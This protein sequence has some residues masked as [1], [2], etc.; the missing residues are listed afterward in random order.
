MTGNTPA[1]SDFGTADGTALRTIEVLKSLGF[2]PHQRDQNGKPFD[3]VMDFGDFQIYAIEGM[4]RQFRDIV[5]LAGHRFTTGGR[6]FH[7]IEFEM[8]RTVESR[9]QG[10]AWLA[11]CLDRYASTAEESPLYPV[12]W[13]AEGRAHFHLLHWER[14]RAERE[15]RQQRRLASPHCY[16]ERE[17]LR[18]ALRRLD[19]LVSDADEDEPIT[20]S[21]DGEI[22]A[23]R[24]LRRLLPVPADGTAWDRRYS[25]PARTWEY[26]RRRF[27]DHHV[28]IWIFEG[29]LSIDTYVYPGV[30]AVDAE[31]S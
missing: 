14:E 12:P 9:E 25:I 29:S 2:V 20:L 26:P 1:T 3:W 23:I 28:S 24:C 19:E 16:A 8:P 6:T 18:L 21:F 4:N 5:G 13:L 11:W 27:M 15:A 10:I 17:W 22:L 7:E 30:L 31:G